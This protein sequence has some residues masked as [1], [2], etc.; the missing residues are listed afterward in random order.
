MNEAEETAKAVQEVSKAVSRGFDSADRLGGF[1]G[2]I[3]GPTLEEVGGVALDQVK[4]W[5]ASRGLRLR[6]KWEEKTKGARLRAVPPSIALPLLEYA[7]IEDSDELQDIFANLLAN[8]SDADFGDEIQKSYVRILSEMSPLEAKI[9]ACIA[10]AK[11][12][13][14][15]S[16]KLPN[17]CV[18]FQ[19]GESSA[20]LPPV[21][22]D[23]DLAI[24]N[25]HRLNLVAPQLILG[26]NNIST[27]GVS[28]TTFGLAFLRACSRPAAQA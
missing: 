19:E 24:W 1:L 17:E 11:E 3:L 14:V 9:L 6:E 28:I 4:Y 10:P 21:P 15:V 27:R 5:R 13:Y 26:G 7:M 25:L 18:I 12:T 23:V 20:G 16:G 22:P 2:K 8:A